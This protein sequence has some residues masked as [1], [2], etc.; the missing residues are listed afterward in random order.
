MYLYIYIYIYTHTYI[1]VYV[2][3]YTYIYKYIYINTC[4][5]LQIRMCT[6][7]NIYEYTQVHTSQSVVPHSWISE[8]EGEGQQIVAPP[9][10]PSWKWSVALHGRATSLWRWRPN[11]IRWHAS[12]CES[13]CTYAFVYAYKCKCNS[14]TCICL[15]IEV[16][17]YICTWISVQKSFDDM[18]LYV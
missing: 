5:H 7:I 10:F 3:T 8:G 12:L 2:Y 11:V 16:Y 4:N 17:M 1:Y 15:W 18:P 6:C 13:K 9:F 14:K